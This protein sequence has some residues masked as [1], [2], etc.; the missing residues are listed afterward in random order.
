MTV[1]P[2]PKIVVERHEKYRGIVQSGVIGG[3]RPGFLEWV[4]YTDETIMDDSLTTVPP[5]PAKSYVKR[6]LQCRL[7]LTAI[8]AKIFS[9]WLADNINKYEK[10][11]GKIAMPK[12]MMKKAKK[13]PPST[14]IS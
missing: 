11:F 3:V 14:M 8:G 6:T 12:E 13:P 2:P 7:V 1:K 5:D 9:Q 4:V 10:T